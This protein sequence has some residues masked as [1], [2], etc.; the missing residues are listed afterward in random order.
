[1]AKI[2]AGDLDQ[3]VKVIQVTETPDGYGG[4]TT[5]PVTVGTVWAKVEPVRG[6]EQVIADLQRGV[7]AYRI[8][9]RNSGHGKSLTT[10]DRLEWRDTTLNVRRAPNAGRKLFRMIEAESG[11]VNA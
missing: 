3:R 1:M 11:V 9:V 5:T 10:N 7:E 6:G 8:H 4:F 2:G